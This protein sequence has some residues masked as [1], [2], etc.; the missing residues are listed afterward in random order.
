MSTISTVVTNILANTPLSSTFGMV[1]LPT[2]QDE[3]LLTGEAVSC[4]EKCELRI[5]G[6][7]CGSC[8]EVSRPLGN[9][10]VVLMTP[11]CRQS[12]ACFVARLAFIRSKLLSW[13]NEAS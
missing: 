9:N 13:Q 11:P 4:S 2:E 3:S 12:K 1:G 10:Y 6:M 8:V 5:E 7:T